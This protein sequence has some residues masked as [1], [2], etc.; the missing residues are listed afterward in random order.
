MIMFFVI[1][2]AARN[3]EKDG[4]TGYADPEWLMSFRKAT[5]EK[6]I[7]RGLLKADTAIIFNTSNTPEEREMNVFGDPLETLWKNCIFGLLWG[8]KCIS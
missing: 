8:K 6:G 7:P 4:L 2:N 3:L 1:R 5:L